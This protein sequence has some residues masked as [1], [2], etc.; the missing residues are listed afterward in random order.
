[1]AVVALA[2]AVARLVKPMRTCGAREERSQF[3]LLLQL[4]PVLSWVVY[5]FAVANV[6]VCGV[7]WAVGAAADVDVV[8]SVNVSWSKGSGVG[9]E[10]GPLS[11]V[12]SSA[13]SCVALLKALLLLMPPGL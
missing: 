11:L 13:L 2:V 9:V 4:L 8:G 12:M 10:G 5:E 7:A 6:E 1:M 3:L